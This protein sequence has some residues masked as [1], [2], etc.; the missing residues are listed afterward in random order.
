[1]IYGIYYSAGIEGGAVLAPV[2]GYFIDRFGFYPSFTIAGIA[3][4]VMT[5]ICSVFL[6]GKRD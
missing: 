2:M 1:M 6:W 4:V 3:V 5:L